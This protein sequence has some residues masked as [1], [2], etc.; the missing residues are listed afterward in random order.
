MKLT[1][2]ILAFFFLSCEKEESI[3]RIKDEV[4]IEIQS[5]TPFR[6]SGNIGETPV[7]SATCAYITSGDQVELTINT[8]TPAFFTVKLYK[9][10]ELILEKSNGTPYDFYIIKEKF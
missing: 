9:N 7:T 3:E 2:L 5:T 6:L 10:N 4:C 8:E 1:L